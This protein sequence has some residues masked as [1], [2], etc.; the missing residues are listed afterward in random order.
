MKMGVVC[1]AGC[2]WVVLDY[3]CVK[4]VV[5]YRDV[6]SS[7][8]SAVLSGVISSLIVEWSRIVIVSGK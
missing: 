7:F 3:T 4:D 1:Y 8:F 2:I 6:K 5:S